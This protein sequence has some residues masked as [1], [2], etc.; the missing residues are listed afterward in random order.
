MS[1]KTVQCRLIAKPE[2][3]R[4]LWE[5]MV[6]RNTTLINELLQ[7][8][9]QHPDFETFRQKGKISSKIVSELCKP[10]KNDLR[11]TGQ[12]VRFYVSAEHVA[13]YTIKSWLAIQRRLQ[14]KL[15]RRR[16]WLEVLKSDDE[17]LQ[18]S[19]YDLSGLRE[20]AAE[21]L[22]QIQNSQT[23][24]TTQPTKR[25]KRKQKASSD[26]LF[27]QLFQYYRDTEEQ[28]ERGAIAYLLKNQCTIPEEEEDPEQFERRRRKVEIQ[29]QRLEDQIEARLPKGRD[30]TG[31]SW[32]EALAIAT[33]TVPQ[34]NTEFKRWQ[35]K[36]LSRSTTVPF[37]VVFE[38]NE[39]LVWSRNEQDRLCVHFN[40]IYGST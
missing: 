28:P 37:P 23:E 25:K 5:L 17:L 36:L 12:P 22:T 33:E 35:A 10:L 18:N 1:L 20:K 4:Y 9:A 27:G 13:D 21:I 19:G 40:L 7:Q 2:T 29:I 32:L 15:D 31:Q 3:R 30:L 6:E 24:S 34:N 16:R 8:I 26:S 39:D 11:F 14:Q 38:T